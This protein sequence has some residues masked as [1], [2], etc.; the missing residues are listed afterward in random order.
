MLCVGA[1]CA[2]C[3]G[4]PPPAP[5]PVEVKVALVAKGDAVVT[6]DLAGDVRASQQVNIR[7]RVGGVIL[8]KHFIDGSRVEEGQVLFS[9]DPL[10]LLAARADARAR[11]AEAQAN[12]AQANQEVERYRPLVDANAIPRQT[13]DTAVTTAQ[14]SSARVDALKAVLT[15]AELSLGYTTVRSPLSGRIGEAQVSEGTLIAAGQ[16]VLAIVSREDPAW[17]YFSIS[18][19]T[20]L[21][22][23]RR[24]LKGAAQPRHVTLT[25]SDGSRYP[26]EG[27]VNFAD[28]AVDPRTGTITL[29]AEFPNPQRVLQPGMFVRARIVME[30]LSGALLVPDLAVQ[31]Q[32][33]RKFVMVVGQGDRAEQRPVTLGPRIDDRW[34]VEKGL[35]EG[36]R[37]VV[38]GLQK[39]RPGTPLSPIPYAAAAPAPAAGGT[40]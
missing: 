34:V 35:T 23:A 13:Y 15:Q 19:N 30:T 40:R 10:E 8:K 32:L 17:I 31:D 37:V 36:E 4:A 12:L 14:Q 1:L 21:D 33:G 28:R 22:L 9:I 39:A 11:L 38:E 7:A 6:E 27:H 20:L 3:K 29:R 16:T 24:Y 2:A 26:E 25:L 5:P 18:E